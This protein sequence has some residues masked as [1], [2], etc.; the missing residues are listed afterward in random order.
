MKIFCNKKG[1]SYGNDTAKKEKSDTVH[2]SWKL[3]QFRWESMEVQ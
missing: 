3:P 2:D 1:E